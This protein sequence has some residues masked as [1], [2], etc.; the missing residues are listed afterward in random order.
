MICQELMS[1]LGVSCLGAVS[2]G[3]SGCL[4][5]SRSVSACLGAVS[6]R[7]SGCLGGVPG[8]LGVSPDVSAVSRGVSGRCLG[9]RCPGMSRGSSGC[10]GVSRRSLGVFCR[11][12]RV[13]LRS[14]GFFRGVCMIYMNGY[15]SKSAFV[16]VSPRLSAVF[17]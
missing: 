12:L 9:V 7:V 14:I 1:C 8:C 2:R 11:C 13:L 16:T 10:L 4:G 6:R 3:V 17:C 5:V 15:V